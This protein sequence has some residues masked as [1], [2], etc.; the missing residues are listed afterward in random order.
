MD[1]YLTKP[2]TLESFRGAL[3]ERAPERKSDQP[4]QM[5][6]AEGPTFL[7]RFAGNRELIARLR[8]S[9]AEGAEKALPAMARAK[10]S[11]D[12][13]ALAMH[14]HTLK[15]ACLSLGATHAAELATELEVAAKAEREEGVDALL[16]R[17]EVAVE[18]TMVEL[19]EALA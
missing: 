4:A 10:E 13:A 5:E 3:A 18:D 12:W 9:F 14:A 16:L 15:G 17:L 19:D 7:S 1:G 2:L 6:H 8:K 11:Q